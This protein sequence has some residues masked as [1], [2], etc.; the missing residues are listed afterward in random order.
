ML[1]SMTWARA[2]PGPRRCAAIAVG[3]LVA[4][5]SCEKPE[6][7][8]PVAPAAA[9]TTTALPSALADRQDGG[10]AD[11]A[12]HP[13]VGTGDA[14][15]DAAQAFLRPAAW[16]EDLPLFQHM[17]PAHPP[18]ETLVGFR[19]DAPRDRGAAILAAWLSAAKAAGYRVVLVHDDAASLVTPGGERFWVSV[20][21]DGHGKLAGALGRARKSRPR[22]PG[23]C[24]PV[25]K[26]DQT[27]N[28]HSSGISQDG[29]L[30]ESSQS[31]QVARHT[32]DVDADGELDLL[33]P[34]L[35]GNATPCPWNLE[36]DVYVMR[37]TCGHRLGRVGPG[38]PTLEGDV[39]DASGFFR[40]KTESNEITYGKRPIPESYD[41]VIDWAFRGKS[42]AKLAERKSGGQCHHCAVSSCSL[43][44]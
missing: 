38:A 20:T 12:A 30:L 26:P 9:P 15:A 16:P 35:K 25:P 34:I 18:T 44:R 11:A 13:F 43:Q 39:P 22:A 21:S 28:V 27:F 31:W 36:Y 5:T 4:V 8:R 2:K 6:T 33:V 14:G 19:L 41:R 7:A 17:S 3:L 23:A 1:E 40:L 37:G 29:E 10:V 42:Y 32:A 24:V